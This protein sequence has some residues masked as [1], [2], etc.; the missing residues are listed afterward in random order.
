MNRI[1][2]L[3]AIVKTLECYSDQMEPWVW[4]VGW[5]SSDPDWTIKDRSAFFGEVA[6]CLLDVIEWGDDG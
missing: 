3:D 2:A 4:H 1:E 6:D 5:D